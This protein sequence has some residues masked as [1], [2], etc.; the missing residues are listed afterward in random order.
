MAVWA[1]AVFLPGAVSGAIN[2]RSCSRYPGHLGCARVHTRAR[3]GAPSRAAVLFMRNGG[4]RGAKVCD[5]SRPR[6]LDKAGLRH[7]S[8]LPAMDS[9]EGAQRAPSPA[10][11]PSRSRRSPPAQPG[12]LAALS[13]P[14]RSPSS[15]RA[16]RPRSPWNAWPRL[17]P[18]RPPPQPPPLP[19]P[20]VRARSQ[21]CSAA[22]LTFFVRALSL[23]SILQ[24]R[25]LLETLASNSWRE[26]GAGGAPCYRGGE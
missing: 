17:I 1:H 5:S 22:R 11:S 15:L 4:G 19:V 10:R 23:L 20:G 12:Y 3:P 26:I 9:T 24:V 16:H 2:T 13:V 8:G 18:A 6:G 14:A 25:G 21:L 7:R